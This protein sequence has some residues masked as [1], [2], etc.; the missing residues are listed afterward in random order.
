MLLGALEQQ[1]HPQAQ[2]Q[3]RHARLDALVQQLVQAGRADRG[4]PRGKRAHAG[5][6]QPVHR[7]QALG[8]GAH[9]HARADVLERLLGRAAVA[10]AVVDHSD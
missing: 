4:H 7:A 3:Q 6:H 10:H 9:L 2:T 5:Q 8:I 1:L